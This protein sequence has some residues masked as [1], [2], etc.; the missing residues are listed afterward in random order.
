YFHKR[1]Y[2]VACISAGIHSVNESAFEVTYSYQDGNTLRPVILVE[3]AGDREDD[4][5]RS[6]CCIRI[7]TAIEDNVFSI[8]DTLLTKSNIR[9]RSGSRSDSAT[10]ITEPTSTYNA[11]LRSEA[12]VASFLKLLHAACV[13]CPAFRDV[14]ILGR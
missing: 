7:L 10:Q 3:P 8:A 9:E 1:A 12:T 6:R 13:K 14:C 11:V 4:F 5:A 2:Y